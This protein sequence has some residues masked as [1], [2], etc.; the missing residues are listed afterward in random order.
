M[1]NPEDLVVL[2][3]DG[4]MHV[5]ITTDVQGTEEA[6]QEAKAADEHGGNEEHGQQK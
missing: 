6:V 5:I 4:T 2:D 3:K 1:L